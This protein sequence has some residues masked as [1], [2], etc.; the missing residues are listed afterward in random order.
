ML[1]DLN[2]VSFYVID[3]SRWVHIVR[4]K[5]KKKK[6]QENKQIMTKS[7]SGSSQASRRTVFVSLM[8]WVSQ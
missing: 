1:D 5:S 2:V 8:E 4:K 6:G 7:R 3:V